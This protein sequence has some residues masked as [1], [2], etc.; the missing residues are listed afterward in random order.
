MTSHTDEQKRTLCPWDCPVSGGTSGGNSLRPLPR[1]GRCIPRRGKPAAIKTL[2]FHHER[3]SHGDL[4]DHPPPLGRCLL[5]RETRRGHKVALVY[6]ATTRP[7]QETGRRFTKTGLVSFHCAD[8]ECFPLLQALRRSHL[9]SPP[10]A[11]LRLPLYAVASIPH[12]SE[13][14]DGLIKG[15]GCF[16]PTWMGRD[17]RSYREEQRIRVPP[18]SPSSP[19]LPITGASGNQLT[20]ASGPVTGLGANKGGSSILPFQSQV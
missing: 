17:L 2:I 20:V 15:R 4:V 6:L 5:P 11:T 10:F 1:S 7:L 16:L 18:R 19:S 13:D 3:L 9:A 12:I 8:N 14:T